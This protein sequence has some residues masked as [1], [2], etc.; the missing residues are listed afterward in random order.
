MT[1]DTQHILEPGESLEQ[2]ESGEDLANKALAAAS[3]SPMPSLSSAKTKAKTAGTGDDEISASNEV[4]ETLSYLQNIIE[5]NAT[6]LMKVKEELKLKRE[7]L[8]SVFENDAQLGE[9]ETQ[10]DQYTAQVKERKAQIVASPQAVSLK[11][12]VGELN[13]QKKEIEETLSNHLLN[14]YALTNSTSFDTSD[15]DQWEFNIRA[16]VKTRKTE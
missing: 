4:A 15:G 14:Y 3:G 6:E 5:R 16:A 7:S 1:D 12:Q 2:L 13:Q 10:L 11:N 8:K 9:A